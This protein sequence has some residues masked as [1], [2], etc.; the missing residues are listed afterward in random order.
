MAAKAYIVPFNGVIKGFCTLLGL[1]QCQMVDSD[2][3]GKPVVLFFK[4]LDP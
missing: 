3:L 4:D 1:S 2:I